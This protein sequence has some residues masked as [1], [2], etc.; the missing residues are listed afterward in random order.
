MAGIPFNAVYKN[1]TIDPSGTISHAKSKGV[2]VAKPTTTFFHLID[3]SGLPSRFARFCCSKLKEYKIS[4]VAVYGIR[5]DESTKRAARYNEPNFC[6]VYNKKEKTHVW[7]PI[8]DWTKDDIQEFVETEKIQC[9]SLYYDNCGGFHAERRLGCQGCPLIS[10]KKRIE[11]FKQNP[12]WLFLYIKHANI[13]CQTH[14][15]NKALQKF[16]CN[17]THMMFFQLFCNNYDEYLYKTTGLFG[18]VDIKAWMEDYFGID[19]T[20]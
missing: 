16:D 4:D 9:H 12:K 18:Q 8:L 13:Y 3:K 15:D 14:V 2:V 1:T 17:G 6:R 11:F 10:Q 7:L 19:L 20:I 5:R